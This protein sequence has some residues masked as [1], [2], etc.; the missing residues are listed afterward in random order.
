MR[1][2]VFLV[3]VCLAFGGC[4]DSTGPESVAGRYTLV[5]IDGIPLP[6]VLE[7]LDEKIEITAGHFQLDSD[8]TCSF[9]TTVRTTT[10]SGQVTT[11]PELDTCTWTLNITTLAVTDSGGDTSTGSVIDG[12]IT[13]GG[14]FVVVYQK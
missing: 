3:V 9:S 13:F 2:F 11:E 6:Y 4:S 10:D 7:D 1:R 8:G 12:T 14:V 5:S